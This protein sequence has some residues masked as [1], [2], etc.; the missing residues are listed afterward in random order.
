A[1]LGSSRLR[2][3]WA[4]A[5]VSFSGDGK[6]LASCGQETSGGGSSAVRLWEV[7][8]GREGRRIWLGHWSQGGRATRGALSPDARRVARS[9]PG[10]GGVSV[11]DVATGR[12]IDRLHRPDGKTNDAPAQ[13]FA[14]A[15]DGKA[16]ATGGE[17]GTLRVWDLSGGGETLRAK[18]GA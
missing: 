17:D 8:S 5:A 11:A 2:H 6:L 15:P 14:F 12:V 10:G 3:T 7:P 4:V 9:G 1:R 16:L 18:V 13:P